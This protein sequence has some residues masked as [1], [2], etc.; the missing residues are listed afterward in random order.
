[1]GERR[2][3]I[4]GDDLLYALNTLGFEKY[5]DALRT[6]LNK[7]REIIKGETRESEPSHENFEIARREEPR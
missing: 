5:L 4:N 3:T 2:K 6:Y 7:Y 1:M